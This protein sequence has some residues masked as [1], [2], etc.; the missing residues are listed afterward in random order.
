MHFVCLLVL[1]TVT[2]HLF[3]L[4][5]SLSDSAA[6]TY[7]LSYKATFYMHCI[8]AGGGESNTLMH[9]CFSKHMPSNGS[10]VS[11]SPLMQKLSKLTTVNF[12]QVSVFMAL[13]EI[14]IH[15]AHWRKKNQYLISRLG[16]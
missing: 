1:L 10:A 6:T 16:S 15:F 2:Q 12:N 4:N 9:S 7:V 11:I 3:S 8:F 5:K 14:H 13:S